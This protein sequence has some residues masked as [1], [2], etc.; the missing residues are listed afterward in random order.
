L[1]KDVEANL[2]E[3]IKA[4]RGEADK[5]FWKRICHYEGGGSGPSYLSGWISVFCLF[6]KD[7]KL[8]GK[9]DDDKEWPRVDTD[10]IPT[11][12]V[13]VDV[14]VDDHGKE[15]KTVMLAGSMGIE[16]GGEGYSLQPKSGWVIAIKEN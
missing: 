5:E 9:F 1:G 7:G 3:F 2:E 6:D 8:Q 16:I 13:E 4:K 12:I 11:G 10:D 15:Y 14:T